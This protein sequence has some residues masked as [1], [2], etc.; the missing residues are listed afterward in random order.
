MVVE[1]IREAR[2]DRQ[3][4]DERTAAAM[5]ALG[6]E[7][8]EEIYNAE[9]AAALAKARETLQEMSQAKASLAL[10]TDMNLTAGIEE[11]TRSATKMG[12]AELEGLAHFK[13]GHENLRENLETI[14]A[15]GTT[16]L[17]ACI[18]RGGGATLSDEEREKM[19]A[20]WDAAV[21]AAKSD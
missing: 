13:R 4:F 7:G 8:I 12:R 15:A 5:L 6:P 18:S 19:R 10:L 21:S 14:I 11:A 20:Q 2:L 16:V 9:P 1:A 3:K 17:L